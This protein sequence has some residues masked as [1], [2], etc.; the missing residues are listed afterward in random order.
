VPIGP[1]SLVAGVVGLSAALDWLGQYDAEKAERWS[2]QLASLAGVQQ[3]RFAVQHTSAHRTIQLVRGKG[4]EVDIQ[5]L[6]D[7]ALLPQ[8]LNARTRLLAIGQMSNVTG[9]CPDLAQALPYSTPVPIGP[10]SLCAEK[11]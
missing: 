10:Y 2:Q 9:G 5:R 4:V 7:I 11:A 1:Y 8:L 3:L 6:H